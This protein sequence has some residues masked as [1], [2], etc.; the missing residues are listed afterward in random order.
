[1]LLAQMT[2]DDVRDGCAVTLRVAHKLYRDLGR[3]PTSMEI[4]WRVATQFQARNPEVGM[5]PLTRVGAMVLARQ[6]MDV[7]TTS[8]NTNP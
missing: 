6:M 5:P 4:Q 2:S 8:T 3:L 7:V 1:M